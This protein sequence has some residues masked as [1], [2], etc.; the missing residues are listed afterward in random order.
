MLAWAG[1]D[2][3]LILVP[4]LL[5][6]R[7]WLF[8]KLFM[9]TIFLRAWIFNNCIILHRSSMRIS[10]NYIPLCSNMRWII[11]IWGW[12]ILLFSLWGRIL[13]SESLST[14]NFSHIS[15]NLIEC[16]W[17]ILCNSWLVPV[18]HT[19]RKT[20]RRTSFI[21][22]VGWYSWVFSM[23]SIREWAIRRWEWMLG[24]SI[25]LEITYWRIAFLFSDD[26]DLELE[27]M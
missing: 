8:L 22:L 7:K 11:V 1:I 24:S 4:C 25:N 2:I 23:L 18:S 15:L 12:I 16:S 17:R 19:N 27:R 20:L 5:T 14:S 21:N 26:I 6:K 9:V 3:V 13:R 10:C